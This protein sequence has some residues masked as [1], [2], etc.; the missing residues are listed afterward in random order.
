MF[1]SEN[2]SLPIVLLAFLYELPKDKHSSLFC[3]R[4]SEEEE[5]FFMAL[6]G[7]SRCRIYCLRWDLVIGFLAFIHIL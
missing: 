6:I 2:M 7:S 4:I 3:W 5:N 1:V